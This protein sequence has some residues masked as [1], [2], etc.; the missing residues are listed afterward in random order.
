MM[1]FNSGCRHA[2]RALLFALFLPAIAQA[3]MDHAMP[4]MAMP[5]ALGI[6][7]NR[8]GSGT[9][10]IPDAVSVPSRHFNA[11][12]WSV[13]LHGFV[14]AQYNQQN[15]SR[16]DRQF[17]SLNWAMLMASRPIAGGVFQ[18][19]TMLSLDPWTVSARGYP[20][21]LQTGETYDG[22]RLYDRQ[23]PHDF[24]MELGV[25]YERSVSRR[26]AVSLYAAPSGE[27]ALGPVAFM[28]R[29]SAIDDPLA[30]LGHHWQDAT[31]I[32]YGVVT[33]GVFARR[34]KLEG[35]L[36]NGREP[37]E[38]RFAMDPI[39]LDSWSS[40]M[41]VN[42]TAN[43]SA[44]LGIGWLK[45]PESLDPLESMRRV[46]GSVI[47]GTKIGALGQWSTTAV[48]GANLHHG[49]WTQSALLESEAEFGG[50]H[51]LFMRTE[52]APRSGEDLN[53]ATLPP[54]ESFRVASVSVGYIKEIA[55]RRSSTTGA[56]LRLA[57][58]AVP[59]SLRQSYGTRTPTGV[60][61]FLRVRPARS[62]LMEM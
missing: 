22:A 1:H 19:R 29:P 44:T 43:W 13:M 23:H 45:S 35:S 61:V 47:H 4:G 34:W 49:S 57:I 16:G 6:S 62:V 56:G 15:G 20:M 59:E 55:R 52:M 26:L 8:M 28:H 11:G 46:V 2:R 12:N 9:T 53:L 17:G 18:A 10:W 39:R 40:R 3:Q 30:P 51:T 60:V 50:R 48:L 33:G 41:T 25:L 32:S 36:F 27:P 37:D 31:H 42:P 54:D 21:L 5:G 14:F 7:M 58:S 38:K 24:W